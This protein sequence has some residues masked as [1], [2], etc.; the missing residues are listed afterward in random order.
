M[1]VTLFNLSFSKRSVKA[2]EAVLK[3]SG[4]KVTNKQ[5]NILLFY[6]VLASYY[7]HYNAV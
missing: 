4:Y 5:T 7:A 3:I 6:L 1:T 2:G